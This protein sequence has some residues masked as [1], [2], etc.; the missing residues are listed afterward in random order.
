MEISTLIFEVWGRKAYGVFLLHLMRH[1]CCSYGAERR[2]IVFWCKADSQV[3]GALVGTAPGLGTLDCGALLRVTP[4][5][6]APWGSIGPHPRTP[7][8]R[9]TAPRPSTRMPSPSKCSSSS[10]S[11]STPLPF[12]SPSSRASKAFG[13]QGSSPSPAALGA[14]GLCRAEGRGSAAAVV[15]QEHRAGGR[16]S[17]RRAEPSQGHRVAP[18][19]CG[20][21]DAAGPSLGP[22]VS[23]Q[24]RHPPPALLSPVVA[25]MR[26][27]GEPEEA[28]PPLGPLQAHPWVPAHGSATAPAGSSA[29]LGTT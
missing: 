6:T 13:E 17:H 10:L 16:W 9:C 29:T 7:P 1:K 27:L 15:G 4:C 11:P 19:C 14:S 3:A 23:L 21:T 28:R 20:L 18:A 25:E 5:G 12:M 8:Q 2:K 22:G 26:A 24:Q